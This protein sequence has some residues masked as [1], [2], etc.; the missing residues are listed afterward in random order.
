MVPTRPLRPM[1][2]LIALLLATATSVAAQPGAP[3]TG[4]RAD[5]DRF[6]G[7]WVGG[8]SCEETGRRGSLS[9]RLAAGADS[10]EATVLM[11]PRPS[12]AAPVPDPVPLTVHAV[13]ISGRSFRGVLDRYEDP[14]LHIPLE[15]T[16]GGALAEADRIEGYFHA[17]GTRIDTVPQCGRWWATRVADAPVPPRRAP[18]TF[19]P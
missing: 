2:P 11:V 1:R 18:N 10:V 15:T 6:V 16:F 9:F 7:E 19:L 4:D 5:L 3:V 13:E 14:E 17:E 8:Y 12:E